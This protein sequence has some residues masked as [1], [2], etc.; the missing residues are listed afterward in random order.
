VGPFQWAVSA[1]LTLVEG[2][3]Q[4]VDFIEGSYMLIGVLIAGSI[5]L[6]SLLLP[7][8]DTL[9]AWIGAF[10]VGLFMPLAKALRYLLT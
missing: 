5:I 10:M 2:V 3:G 4:L 8:L 1:P 7:S 9:I 6:S